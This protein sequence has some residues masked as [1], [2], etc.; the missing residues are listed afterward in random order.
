MYLAISVAAV[1]LAV[2]DMF[3]RWVAY[4]RAHVSALSEKLTHL[5]ESNR[6]QKAALENFLKQISDV[7]GY[8]ESKKRDLEMKL[9]G[10]RL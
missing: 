4:D 8:S 10:K 9:V 7:V 1:S 5:V 3:R 6:L 2:W